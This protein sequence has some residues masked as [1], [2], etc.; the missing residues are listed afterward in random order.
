MY[1]SWL[2]NSS[3][4]VTCC[5][6]KIDKKMRKLFHKRVR[7]YKSD[8]DE[9]DEPLQEARRAV[10]VKDMFKKSEDEFEE[11]GFS[12][13]GEKEY[14]GFDVELVSEDE[15]RRIQPGHVQF[16]EGIKAFKLAFKKIVKKSKVDEDV[17]LIKKWRKEAFFS[18]L[19]RITSQSAGTVVKVVTS[20]GSV[21]G[22]GPAWAPLRDNYML[23]N[24]K[25]KDWDKIQDTNTIDDFGRRSESDSDDD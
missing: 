6:I 19:G 11:D 25:L 22:E 7:D 21:G 23:T 9:E 13:D 12:D 3:S 1:A 15:N 17:F 14:E 20:G 2:K 18:E 8:G 5:F 10:G 16:A 4:N 24:P